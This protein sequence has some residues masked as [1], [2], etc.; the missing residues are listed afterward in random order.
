MWAKWSYLLQPLTA[1]TQTKVTFKCTDVE[2][3][4]RLIKLN[5]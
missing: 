4:R 2:K 5:E 1:L 3:K